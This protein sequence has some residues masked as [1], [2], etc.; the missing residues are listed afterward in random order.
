[1]AG[2]L[3]V[4]EACGDLAEWVSEKGSSSVYWF[5]EYSKGGESLIFMY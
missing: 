4:G 1:M 2:L 5:I 3:L